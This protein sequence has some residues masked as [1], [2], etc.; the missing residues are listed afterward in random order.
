MYVKV[1]F[2]AQKSIVVALRWQKSLVSGP[3]GFSEV[4]NWHPT[5]Q[6]F[7]INSFVPGSLP[8]ILPLDTG[9]QS[10]PNT[11]LSGI[12]LLVRHWFPSGFSSI[13]SEYFLN[14]SAKMY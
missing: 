2:H 9:H 12:Y 5:A 11:Y 4:G 14:T 3:N 1:G 7:M 6:S 10:N 13:V 8:F